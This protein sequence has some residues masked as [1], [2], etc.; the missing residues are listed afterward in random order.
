MSGKSDQRDLPVETEWGTAQGVVANDVRT[1]R[2]IPYAALLSYRR[3]ALSRTATHHSV[4]R[5]ARG[6]SVWSHP[7]A[8]TWLRACCRSP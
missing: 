5:R 7:Y 6:G 2:A 4:E 3:V 8:A 1:W